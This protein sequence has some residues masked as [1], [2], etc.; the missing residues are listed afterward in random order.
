MYVGIG[1]FQNYKKDLQN[2]YKINKDNV[3]IFLIFSIIVIILFGK[4]YKME[5]ATDTYQVFNFSEQEV[6]N[7]FASSGRFVSAIVFKFAKK[8]GM[9]EQTIYAISFILAI[10]CM[11][12]SLVKMYK[13]IKNDINSKVLKILIP[14]LIVS[15]FFS[16]ELFLFIEKGIMIF[17]I[18]MCIIGIENVIKFWKTSNK[19]YLFFS[20]ISMFIANCSYQGVVGIFTSVLL[21]Y[22]LKY[23]KTIKEFIK[24]NLIIGAIYAIPA[25]IDYLLVKFLYKQNRLNGKVEIIESIKIVSINFLKMIKNMYGLMPK[26]VFILAILFTFSILCC[27]IW[28]IDKKRIHILKFIYIFIGIS[29]FAVAPQILQPTSNIW[30]VPRS[31]YCFSSIYGILI[32]YL[33]IN[34]TLENIDEKLIILISIFLLIFQV[35]EFWLIEKD[36]YILNKKDYEV[37]MQIIDKINKYESETKNIISKIEVY[38]DSSIK[39]TYDGLFAV[40]DMNV[41]CYAND[42]STVAILNYYLNRNLKLDNSQ[43]LSNNFKNKDW[44]E[45]DDDQIIFYNDTIALCKY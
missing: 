9:K 41:K 45:F 35:H 18:L 5:Y 14:I 20:L 10:L 29:A 4:L 33:S 42:W 26:Y 2:N 36:R 13:I 12:L 22:I 19:K 3:K 32:L 43:D 8:I 7:Q 37:T 40:G 30:L 23:S 16:I 6:Y 31:T 21:V 34:Y 27:K 1:F 28:N 39:Y 15:N 24:N 11:I 25:I 44:N 38:Q 17:G